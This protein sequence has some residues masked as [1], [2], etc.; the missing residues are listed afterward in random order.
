VEVKHRQRRDRHLRPITGQTVD[1][2]RWTDRQLA[3]LVELAY[4]L[5]RRQQ[6]EGLIIWREVASFPERVAVMVGSLES[7]RD[8]GR[9][10]R[11]KAARRGVR[12]TPLAGGA[13]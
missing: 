13:A 3:E 6:R 7:S 5:G 2:P 12:H 11:R 4:T 8:A 1:I 10:H 9:R